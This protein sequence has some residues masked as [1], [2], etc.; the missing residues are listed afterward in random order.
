MIALEA[1]LNKILEKYLLVILAKGTP[2]GSNLVMMASSQR[3][4]MQMVN[5]GSG[6]GKLAKITGR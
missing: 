3:Q 5:S 6:I 1:I 2:V 4:E